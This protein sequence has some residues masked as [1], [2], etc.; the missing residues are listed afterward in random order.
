MQLHTLYEQ[1]MP[2]GWDTGGYMTITAPHVDDSN[3][4]VAYRIRF[5]GKVCPRWVVNLQGQCLAKIERKDSRFVHDNWTFE[6]FYKTGMTIENR[7]Y[8]DMMLKKLMYKVWDAVKE[9]QADVVVLP[10]DITKL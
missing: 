1:V 10:I 2:P 7:L 4:L 5:M 6:Y 8:L 9:K 3:Q